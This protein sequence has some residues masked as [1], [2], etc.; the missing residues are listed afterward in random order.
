MDLGSSR[1]SQP[2]DRRVVNSAGATPAYQAAEQK[3]RVSEEPSVV[4][5]APVAPTQPS[6]KSK[7]PWIIGLI[8]LI[9]VAAAVAAWVLLGHGKSSAAGI[10]STKYQTV[11][12]MNGQIY[13]GK[14]TAIGDTQYKLTNVYYLQTSTTDAANEQA[15][16]QSNAANNSQLIKLSN[17]VYGPEDAMVISKEQV[18]YFQNLNPE[19]RA[20]QLIKGN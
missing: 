15:S 6:K 4:R 2:S 10:D 18:L 8:A 12:L 16:N 3:P 9:L 17:A 13:F 19:G 7:L 5:R 1:P 20:A 11:Y 14:L